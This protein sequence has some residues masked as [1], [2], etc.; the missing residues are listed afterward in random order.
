MQSTD[1]NGPGPGRRRSPSSAPMNRSFEWRDLDKKKFFFFSPLISLCVRALTHPANLVN[2]KVK[3]QRGHALY[4]NPWDA[5]KKTIDRHGI[6]GLYRGFGLSS[7]M[8]GVHQIYTLTYEYLRSKERYDRFGLKLSE[9]ARNGLSA[10][11]S[12]MLVQIIANPIDVLSQRSMVG[13]RAT[14][15]QIQPAAANTLACPPGTSSSV[16]AA[17][18]AAASSSSPSSSSSHSSSSVGVKATTT[19]RAAST[20]TTAAGA[21]AASASSSSSSA[22]LGKR[23]TARELFV[24]VLQSHGIKGFFSGFWISAAQFVPSTAL[25]WSC[26]PVFRDGMLPSLDSFSRR[27]MAATSSSSFAELSSSPSSSPSAVVDDHTLL[28]QPS[29]PWIARTAE[30]LAGASA[31]AVVAVSMNPLDLIR[32]R[33]QTGG[34]N[35]SRVFKELIATEGGKGLWKG[36]TARMAMLIPQGALSIMAYE[37]V[38]R[39]SQKE[40][41][42]SS[43]T[44]SALEATSAVSLSV[45]SELA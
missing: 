43:S 22:L 44:S 35:A 33:V 15:P 16:A 41:G 7:M 42:S 26:Y 21:A 45:P 4:K 11:F 1:P 37:L 25:W 12:V 5:F 13:Q 24:H 30:V 40:G 34:T 28:Y 8:L 36:T 20:I 9:S 19:V 23:M 31:S 29:S 6:R 2:T 32:C 18:A 17:S 39:L 10:G 3:A 38:K 14:L 27:W